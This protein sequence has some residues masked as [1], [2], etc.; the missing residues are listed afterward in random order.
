[1]NQRRSAHG[2]SLLEVIL[3]LAIM[4]GAMVVLGELARQGLRYAERA[5]DV[6]QAL[7]LCESK[8]AEYASTVSQASGSVATALDGGDMGNSQSWR[9]EV[10]VTTP[11]TQGLLAVQ[12]TVTK[13]SDDPHPVSV[14]LTRWMID[15]NATFTEQTSEDESNSS[16]SMEEMQQ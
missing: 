9:S 1:M 2:F 7:I 3:A 12:V 16:S 5:R 10:N 8:L 15:P 11:G 4:A 13:V 6:T 14:T